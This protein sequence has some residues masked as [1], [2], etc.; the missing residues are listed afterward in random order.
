MTVIRYYQHRDVT[1]TSQYVVAQG[2]RYE[3]AGLGELMRTKGGPH[4]GLIVGMVI[5]V[6]EAGLL[7]PLVNVLRSPLAWLLAMSALLI[8]CAVGL[9][10]ARRWPPQYEL[11]ARYRGRQVTVYACRNELEFGQVARAV[12]RAVERATEAASR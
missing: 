5:A 8:P 3:T 1:V 11:H 4:P 9:I 2:Y 10:C 12:Q 7:V 6:A